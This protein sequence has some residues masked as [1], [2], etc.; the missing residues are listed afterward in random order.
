MPWFKA[1]INNI[2]I[3]DNSHLRLVIT[4]VAVLIVSRV[5]AF[6]FTPETF[7]FKSYY[8][9]DYWRIAVNLFE[10]KG[11]T[12]IPGFPTTLR[13]PVNSIIWYAAIYLFGKEP[14]MIITLTLWSFEIGTVILIYIITHYL[15]KDKF[16]CLIASLLFAFSIPN[17]LLTLGTFSEPIFTLL[18]LVT[19]YIFLRLLDDER[20][21]SCL[22]L[23]ISIGLTT[24]TRSTGILLLV[25]YLFIL[26][27]SKFKKKKYY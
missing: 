1:Y 22:L 23:G 27:I 16:A 3:Q 12:I 13:G 24:L 7:S 8:H 11:Y 18:L 4:V 6:S 2:K 26:A 21:V 25:T 9:D 14:S 20:Y 15:S 19:F 5:A 10:G 17:A